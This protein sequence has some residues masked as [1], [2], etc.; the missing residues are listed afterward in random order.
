MKAIHLLSF[1][2]LMTF[3]VGCSV[4]AK[5]NTNPFHATSVQV[6]VPKEVV[7]QPKQEVETV[8]VA[9][10]LQDRGNL[11]EF[12]FSLEKTKPSKEQLVDAES[13]WSDLIADMKLTNE[14]E[15]PATDFFAVAKFEKLEI[16][17]LLGLEHPEDQVL[18]KQDGEYTQ[19][20]VSFEKLNQ[21]MM[22]LE[23]FYPEN[24]TL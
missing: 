11:R 18:V 14:R 7:Q 23:Q 17:V 10:P 15:I 9:S 22:W 20:A 12:T 6:S 2:F 3:L 24:E 8:A 16:I 13:R 19:Y 1:A 21:A 5:D 4:Q